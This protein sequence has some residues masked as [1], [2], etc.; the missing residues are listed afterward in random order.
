MT[1]VGA[2]F[3]LA[4]VFTWWM[5]DAALAGN[6][7]DRIEIPIKQTPVNTGDIRYSIPVQVGGEV[8]VALFDTGST[9]LR[10]LSG[11]VPPSSYSATQQQ[12]VYDYASGNYL[13]GVIA[14][15][16]IRLGSSPSTAAVPF[17]LV[18]KIQCTSGAPKC[19]A[20]QSSPQDPNYG[21]VAN[22][23]FRAI[24]GAS[25]P[26]PH[27][28]IATPNPLIQFGDAWIVSLP[29]PGDATA[30]SLI[31]N[32]S[33]DERSGFTLFPAGQGAN[34][35]AGR[36]NPIPGCF[37]N[38][39][40][41]NTFCGPIIIDT[42]RSGVTIITVAQDY[43]HWLPGINGTIAFN[44]PNGQQIAAQ[45]TVLA[46]FSPTLVQ[47][48]PYPE[49][50]QPPPREL[51]GVLPYLKFYVLYDYKNGVIGLKAR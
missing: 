31:M 43:A 21:L 38:N 44:E 11:V 40:N 23:G 8:I 36:D 29:L 19:P 24:I 13:L 12:A 18:Q 39:G 14:H 41:R 35:G 46:N 26:S 17:Q 16:N 48:G 45:F 49:L 22:D 1:T 34:V 37:T 5:S 7:A 32:P 15:A 51:A 3:A 42:G 28:S 50:G 4:L 20:S 25:M 33:A 30:G 47:R 9:G 10:V 6:T 2:N 27:L